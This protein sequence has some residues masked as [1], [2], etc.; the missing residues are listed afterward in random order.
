MREG[1]TKP[2]PKLTYAQR[3]LFYQAIGTSLDEDLDGESY[4]LNHKAQIGFFKL[5][6]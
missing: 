2:D 1:E 6:D 3:K 5:R 4:Y